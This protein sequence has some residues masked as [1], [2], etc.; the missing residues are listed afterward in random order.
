LYVLIQKQ[1]FEYFINSDLEI[2]KP[3]R[4][5]TSFNEEQI[6]IL[7]KAYQINSFLDEAD[8]RYL[9]NQLGVTHK[10]VTYWFQNRRVRANSDSQ[11]DTWA[12]YI[13]ALKH[14]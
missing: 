9:A 7:E 13:S 14:K 10:N 6:D 11:L 4:K 5:R 1:Q 2:E 8:K 3:I 12:S